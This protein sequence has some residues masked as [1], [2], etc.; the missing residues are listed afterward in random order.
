MKSPVHIYK[1]KSDGWIIN[2]G[3]EN[4]S[5]DISLSQLLQLNIEDARKHISKAS[6]EVSPI[7]H[8]DHLAPIDDNQEVWACGVTYLRSKVG[9]MEESDLPDLYSRVYDALRPEI[10]FKS[11][12]WR[13]VGNKEAVGIRADSGW[14]VPEG[15]VGLVVNAH[16]EIFGYVIGNDMSSRSIEGENA[17]YLP[18]AKCYEKSCALGPYIV[19]AWEIDEAVF[20]IKVSIKRDGSEVFTGETSSGQMKRNFPELVEWLFK[21]LPMPEGAIVLTGTGVVPDSSFT[22]L[23]GD[24]VDISIQSLGTLSNHVVSVGSK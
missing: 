6:K 9:R 10:F 19:P 1:S 17:L 7:A 15:E 18:Q 8:R 23:V 11:S 13:A 5:L 22:L 20:P 3:E 24:V 12:G 14:D 4:K 16:G 21:T 2:Q